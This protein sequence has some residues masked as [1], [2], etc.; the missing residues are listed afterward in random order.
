LETRRKPN[1]DSTEDNINICATE[2]RGQG[3]TSDSRSVSNFRFHRFVEMELKG[4]CEFFSYRINWRF[5][6]GFVL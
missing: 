2:L 6:E 3:A 1:G 5:Y 4:H